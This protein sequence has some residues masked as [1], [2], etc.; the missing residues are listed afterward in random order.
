MT[1]EIKLSTLSD[2]ELSALEQQILAEQSHRVMHSPT[3]IVVEPDASDSAHQ[4]AIQ[5][6][7]E[8]NSG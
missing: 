4:D 6:L 2:Q 5:K 8:R 1:P 3:M 7:L